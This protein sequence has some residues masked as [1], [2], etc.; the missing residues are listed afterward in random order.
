MVVSVL[1]G[2]YFG[3]MMEAVEEVAQAHGM[4]LIVVSDHQQKERERRAIEFLLQ[5]R[6]DGLVLHADALDDEELVTLC[7]STT[8]PMVIINRR[9]DALAGRHVHS[10]DTLGAR[11]AVAHLVARGHRRIGCISGPLALHES[12]QRLTGYRDGMAEAGLEVQAD[13]IV[14]SD[15]SLA[16]G[17]RGI[18]T[19]LDRHPEI[20]GVF[21]QND[22]MAAG[23]L[24]ACRARG[25]SLPRD[26]SVVGFDDVEWA[27]YLHPRLT[28][29]RQPV[30]AMGL[31]AG[32]LLLQMLGRKPVDPDLPTFFQPELIARESVTDNKSIP[33]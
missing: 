10:D 21:V 1:S 2:P 6:C 12:R 4:H 33:L 25:M 20:T 15:F 8:T 17:T 5:R 19:S 23:V 27:R 16:G 31:S 14:E 18:D 32:Q 22:Q 28:T 3:P 30:H 13:W 11:L 7:Q 9:M 24:D 26:L 29:V